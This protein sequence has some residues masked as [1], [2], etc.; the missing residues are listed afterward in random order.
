MEKQSIQYLDPFSMLIIGE[1]GK[2]MR[3]HCPFK[4]RCREPVTIYP[5]QT[6]LQVEKVNLL[7]EDQIY[8]SICGKP[9]LSSLFEIVDV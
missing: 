9:F 2:L 4:V 1:N 6:I 3:L 8:Y 5:A 7:P